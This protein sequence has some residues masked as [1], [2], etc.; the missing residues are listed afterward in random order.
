MDLKIAALIGAIEDIANK[1]EAQGLIKEAAELDMVAN[2][3]EVEAGMMG[4]WWKKAQQFAKTLGINLTWDKA[5]DIV[6]KWADD[7][8]PQMLSQGAGAEVMQ[9]MAAKM[10]TGKM[11]AML[12]AMIISGF[13]SQIEAR[14][15]PI[16]VESPLGIKTY[17]AKELRQLSK[18][19]PKSFSIV[20]EQ[21]QKQQA[22]IQQAIHQRQQGLER[23]QRADKPTEDMTTV[24]D[25]EMKS[26]EFG[27]EAKLITFEDGS[28]QL[29]GDIMFGGKSLRTL[30]EQ[31]GEIAKDPNAPRVDEQT[32]QLKK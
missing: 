17:T 21:S 28:K 25:T 8:D 22:K 6:K 15:K 14:G 4:D 26:D 10:G 23:A 19:D 1:C 30:M 31:N 27:N 32:H 3:L 13:I 24:K 18:A 5:I 7:I 9:R 2:T 11:M 20:M 12:A 29:D 16:T